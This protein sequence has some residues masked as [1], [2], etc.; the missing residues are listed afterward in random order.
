MGGG[1]AANKLSTGC[2]KNTTDASGVVNVPDEEATFLMWIENL[3]DAWLNQ[4]AA[5]RSLPGRVQGSVNGESMLTSSSI[6]LKL[7]AAGMI[8]FNRSPPRPGEDSVCK[9]HLPN[10]IHYRRG[11][12]SAA[13][14]S[15]CAHR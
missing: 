14:H 15:R 4:E 10:A 6:A 3:S 5:F 1:G 13:F 7:T 2:R 11:V 9:T 8:N 12:R